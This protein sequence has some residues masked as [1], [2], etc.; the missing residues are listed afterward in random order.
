MAVS[1][2]GVLN[3]YRASPVME[4]VYGFGGP[5]SVA[6]GITLPLAANTEAGC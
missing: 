3:T 1:R 2:I 4:Y 5:K 6:Y